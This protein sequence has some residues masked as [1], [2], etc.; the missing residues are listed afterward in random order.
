MLRSPQDG[1]ELILP[2]DKD[3][4]I[5]K[6]DNGTWILECTSHPEVKR[7]TVSKALESKRATLWQEP[8]LEDEENLSLIHI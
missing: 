6:D 3:F 2:E 8:P 4:Q 7:R 5:V 1:K